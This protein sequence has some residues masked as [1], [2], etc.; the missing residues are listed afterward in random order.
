M[1][2]PNSNYDGYLRFSDILQIL[3]EMFLKIMYENK[4]CMY[5]P[6]FWMVDWF[7]VTYNYIVD[8]ETLKHL[9]G[10]TSSYVFGRAIYFA[11]LLHIDKEM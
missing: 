5:V 11:T 6:R 3:K 10:I 9:A 4:V 1:I 2:K 7:L 8:R